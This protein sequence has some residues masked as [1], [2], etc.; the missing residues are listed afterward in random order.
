M[1]GGMSKIEYIAWELAVAK[2]SDARLVE[3]KWRDF[4][5]MA[6][7]IFEVLET[8]GITWPVEFSK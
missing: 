2:F 4:L 1:E 5:P 7:D 3:E 8:P 6:K